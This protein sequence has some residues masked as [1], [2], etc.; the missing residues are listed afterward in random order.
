MRLPCLA[1][2]AA[3]LLFSAAAL[4]SAVPAARAQQET[5][6]LRHPAPISIFLRVLAHVS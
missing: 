3:L 2:S 5:G 1:V 4:L 6:E